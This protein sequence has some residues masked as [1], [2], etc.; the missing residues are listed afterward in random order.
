MVS[1]VMCIFVWGHL[2]LRKDVKH[3]ILIVSNA[4]Y[5]QEI[6]TRWTV[7]SPPVFYCCGGWRYL[8]FFSTKIFWCTVQSITRGRR[9]WQTVVSINNSNA[10]LLTLT[11]FC[12][13][14]GVGNEKGQKNVQILNMW[15]LWIKLEFHPYWKH[16]YLN[17]FAGRFARM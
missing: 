17:G 12:G 3:L 9:G 5:F 6:T 13:Q 16:W 11:L 4:F 1:E 8:H 7:T 10:L 15:P 14:R 2:G